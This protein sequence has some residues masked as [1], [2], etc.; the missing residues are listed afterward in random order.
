[1][2]KI[3]TIGREFGSG[4]REFGRRLAE[5]LGFDYYDKEIISE[6]AKHTAL[7]EN[8]VQQVIEKNPHDLFPITVGHSFSYVD[9][10]TLEKK[11]KVFRAQEK[12]IKEMAEKSNCVIVGRCGDYI[13]RD[14]KPTKIFLYADIEAK[15]A[16]C[17]ARNEAT[18]ALS[19]KKLKKQIKNIDKNRARYYEF[20]TG[21]TWGNKLNYDLCINT[22]DSDIRLLVKTVAAMFK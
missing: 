3:I 22:T 12:V 18:E 10:Y 15:V 5:E 8:Y 2:N 20:F 14:Y 9:A 4:G 16:R 17:K 21:E 19:D 13:L 11:Q 7:S 6:I 1:M